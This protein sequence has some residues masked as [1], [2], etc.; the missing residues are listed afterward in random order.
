[1]FVKSNALLSETLP[2]WVQVVPSLIEYHQMPLAE[3]APTMA[4][5]ACA[6]L[7]TSLVLPPKFITVMPAPPSVGTPQPVLLLSSLIAP[8]V[9]LTSLSTGAS[10]TALTVTAT[11]SLALEVADETGVAVVDALLPAVPADWSHAL[12]VSCVPPT[13]PLKLAVVA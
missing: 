6:P 8:S 11:V 13:V 2:T 4:I 3:F 9:R 12:K 1:M 5:P 7:S 10:F